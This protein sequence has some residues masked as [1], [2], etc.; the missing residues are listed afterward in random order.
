MRKRVME[1]LGRA[2]EELN[3]QLPP[4]G[5]L[6]PTEDERV[7]ATGTKLDSLG[8]VS[9]IVAVEQEIEAEFE[10]RYSLLSTHEPSPENPTYADL[11]SLAEAIATDLG[12]DGIAGGD[13]GA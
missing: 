9:L 2:V 10:T 3:L 1:A 11:G 13:R 5:R 8:F 4:E 6:S 12:A 7:L